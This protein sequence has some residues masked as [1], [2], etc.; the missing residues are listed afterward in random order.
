MIKRTDANQKHIVEMVRK[1]PGAS[2]TSTHIIGKGFPDLVI[3]YKGIN[4]LIELKDGA[5]PKSQK[6]LTPDEV[7]FHLKW[8]GQIAICENFEDILKIL[9]NIS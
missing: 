1:L 9:K 2:I 4:Y 6:K 5:K 3:G 7:E 8:N